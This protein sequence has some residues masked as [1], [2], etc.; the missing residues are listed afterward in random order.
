VGPMEVEEEEVV[1]RRGHAT[2]ARRK[3]T[4]ALTA[5]NFKEGEVEGEV[6][7]INS[8]QAVGV[9]RQQDPVINAERPVTGVQNVQKLVVAVVKDTNYTLSCMVSLTL[10]CGYYCVTKLLIIIYLTSIVLSFCCATYT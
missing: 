2:D 9:V 4:G 6:M 3:D 1:D 8:L 7:A 5:L 10:S